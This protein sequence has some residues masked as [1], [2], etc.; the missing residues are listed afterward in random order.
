MLDLD[1]YVAANPD[2]VSQTLNG[3]AVLL[4]PAKGEVK[5]LNEVGA[6][7][8]S[9]AHER[10]TLREI[11]AVICEEYAV[12]Q[13]DAETDVRAFVA[14]LAERGMVAIFPAAR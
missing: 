10:Q 2:I 7:I 3:E 14:E 9:L 13:T 12:A 8:W 4:L 1:T 5:V 6:R 11:A